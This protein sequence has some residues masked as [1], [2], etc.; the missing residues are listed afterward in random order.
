MLQ[1]SNGPLDKSAMTEMLMNSLGAP[2]PAPQPLDA[3]DRV[4]YPTEYAPE[5]LP[6]TPYRRLLE[7]AKTSTII[8]DHLSDSTSVLHRLSKVSHDFIKGSMLVFNMPSREH[9]VKYQQNLTLALR[10]LFSAFSGVSFF[11]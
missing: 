1:G 3:P 10:H 5:D 8:Q 11:P 4:L 7:G 2:Q 9:T 6:D